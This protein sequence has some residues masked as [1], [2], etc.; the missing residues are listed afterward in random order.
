ME[1]EELVSTWSWVDYNTLSYDSNYPFVV[2]LVVI[3]WRSVPGS[4]HES[5]LMLSVVSNSTSEKLSL[6]TS[7][8][9]ELHIYY[10]T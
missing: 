10:G 6:S 9:A 5:L 3:V 7:H 8:I 4:L 1:I 2:D